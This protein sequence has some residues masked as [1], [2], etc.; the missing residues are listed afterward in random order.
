MLMSAKTIT[1]DFNFW[2]HKRPFGKPSDAEI[3]RIKGKCSHYSKMGYDAFMTG[4]ANPKHWT[5]YDSRQNYLR[6][7]QIV[8]CIVLK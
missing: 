3:Q 7:L 2:K 4:S 1:F 8:Q 5:D 6:M